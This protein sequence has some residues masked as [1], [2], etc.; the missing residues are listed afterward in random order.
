MN[1]FIATGRIASSADMRK[2]NDNLYAIIDIDIWRHSNSEKT[3]IKCQAYGIDA[4]RLIHDTEIG[5]RI[6]F[7]AY[8]EYSSKYKQ[9]IFTIEKIIYLSVDDETIV[10]IQLCESVQRSITEKLKTKLN[11]QSII[12]NVETFTGDDNVSEIVDNFIQVIA[13]LD[14]RLATTALTRIDK[15][16]AQYMIANTF[17]RISGNYERK[18]INSYTA[19]FK[20]CI[21]NYSTQKERA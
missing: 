5:D 16:T 11:T 18:K 1:K 9:L 13:T 3:T 6:E 7:E 20:K 17:E 21:I 4:N 14:T 12:N 15:Q 10:D 19:Y 8:V 2:V